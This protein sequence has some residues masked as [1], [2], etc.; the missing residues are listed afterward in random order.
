M[1]LAQLAS[2]GCRGKAW[3]MAAS[4][5]K[6][7]DLMEVHHRTG[8]VGGTFAQLTLDSDAA[9]Q[10]ENLLHL[11]SQCTFPLNFACLHSIEHHPCSAPPSGGQSR[12][13]HAPSVP[14]RAGEPRASLRRCSSAAAPAAQRSWPLSGSVTLPA[15]KG[16][17][18]GLLPCSKPSW[19]AGET[20]QYTE[21]H[22]PSVSSPVAPG[23]NPPAAAAT[24]PAVPRQLGRC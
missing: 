19:F 4:G 18:C 21:S 10:N 20:I 22:P 11:Y 16:C 7:N 9:K 24:V 8:K 2:S 13:A 15:A 5:T 6:P 14:P 23:R 3:A 12:C 17:S 1:G